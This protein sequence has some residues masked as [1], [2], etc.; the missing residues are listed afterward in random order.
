MYIFQGREQVGNNREG[1][2]IPYINYTILGP[3]FYFD[4]KI[5][6]GNRDLSGT[7]QCR[8]QRDNEHFRIIYSSLDYSS[9]ENEAKI[10][11]ER[12][13]YLQKI[14]NKLDENDLLINFTNLKTSR[15]IEEEKKVK[16]SQRAKSTQQRSKSKAPQ[17]ATPQENTK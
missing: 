16:T 6:N 17:T 2:P 10:I 11:K 4:I 7:E 5:P 12:K 15:Q 8:V 14:I 9:V 3:E 13:E 1:I